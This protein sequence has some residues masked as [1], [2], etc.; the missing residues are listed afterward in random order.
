MCCGYDFQQ[1]YYEMSKCLCTIDPYVTLP[2]ARNRDCCMVVVVDLPREPQAGIGVLFPPGVPK[3][4]CNN[5]GLI[6]LP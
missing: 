3:P 4:P 2:G 1:P 6:N 5:G